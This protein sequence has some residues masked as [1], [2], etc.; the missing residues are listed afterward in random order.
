MN[1]MVFVYKERRQDAVPSSSSEASKTLDVEA[2]KLLES[3]SERSSAEC[4]Q[5]VVAEWNYESNIT[6]TTKEKKLAA[7]LKYAEW[8][9]QRWE[10]VM[11]WKD[12]WNQLSDP[13]LKRKFVK[14][15]ILGTAA[16]PTAELDKYNGIVTDM[17]TIY[18]TAKV[19][20][21]ADLSLCHLT[22]EPDLKRV[23]RKSRDYNELQFYWERWRNVTGGKMRKMYK[24]FVDLSNKAAQLNDFKNMGDMWLE[25]YESPTF[26]QDLS[27]IWIQLKPLYQQLHA[28]VRRKLREIYSE[29]KISLRGPIPAHLLG[30]MWA[31]SW[32]EVYSMMTPYEGKG[33]LDVTD[34]MKAQ[35]YTPL[36]MFKLSEE[37]FTSLNQTKMPQEFWDHSIIEKPKDREIV[38]HA[39]AWDFCNGVDFRIKQCTDI[40]MSDLVTVHHEMG[41]IQYYLQ[42]KHQPI[43]FRTGANPGF[44]EAVG[45]VLALSVATPKHLH[46]IGL[47]K[48]VH[49][50]PQADINFLMSMALDKIVFL[51]FG[52]LMDLWR[53]DV[54]SGKT[55]E[56]DWNC[57][58]WKLREDLQGI[59]PPSV[60]TEADFDPGSKFH[61]PAN[62]PYVRYFVSFVIQFQFHKS[63]CLKAGQYDPND[64]TKPL[65]K[66]DIYQS[67][68]AG[69]ALGD[70][71]QLGSSKPWP[72]A[73]KALTGET[74]MDAS[75]IREY[76]SPLEKWLQ[77]D[78]QKHGE[79]IGWESDGV[80]CKNDQP[81]P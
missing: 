4:Y 30:N 2:E 64:P 25:P 63:L 59:R 73:M 55:K 22:L 67:T 6:K 15:S 3:L 32:S 9:K 65:H 14:M 46:K 76:F 81:T 21:F 71:L 51:P 26:R 61:I 58:W 41:H 42:Y 54:F 43:V 12:R 53:W 38:C 37:F 36:R 50:D 1:E 34:E 77:E 24:E 70:M 79:F 10:Q 62:Y 72:E 7:S 56:K 78:N 69:N 28:Y 66:C 27:D 47:L 80:Y 68:E 8:E 5:Q 16:L 74:K 13:F 20:D 29:S 57:A 44:H 11:A 39:S 31:Q 18:S 17:T 35:S 75:A 40:T 19:C 45:D 33:S 60:R 48:E 49:D 52:Y 23:L